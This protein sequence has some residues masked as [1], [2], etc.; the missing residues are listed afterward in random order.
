MNRNERRR[1]ER[2]N[3]KEMKNKELAKAYAM[4]KYH[5]D[6]YKAGY[7][8]GL[9]EGRRQMISFGMNMT[10]YMANYKLGLG[11][12]RLSKFMY[13]LYTTIDC[14][15]TGQLDRSD[16]EEIKDIIRELGFCMED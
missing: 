15:N 6:I 5:D 4:K 14:Y 9:I 3:Q 7:E 13:E 10:A 8:A 11:K 1:I 12:K 2:E 16:Y